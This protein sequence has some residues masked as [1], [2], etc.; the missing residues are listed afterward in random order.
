MLKDNNAVQ[1]VTPRKT[2]TVLCQV[3]GTGQF[4]KV[5]VRHEN[6]RPKGE[7]FVQVDRDEEGYVWLRNSNMGIVTAH[8]GDWFSDQNFQAREVNGNYFMLLTPVTEEMPSLEQ[9][10]KA[11]VVTL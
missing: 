2:S 3:V 4:I 9:F 1:T 6:E 7:F 8:E 10:K 11:T 5:N